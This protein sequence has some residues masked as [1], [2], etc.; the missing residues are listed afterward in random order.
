M[1]T[2]KTKIASEIVLAF[3]KNNF[4]NS[5]ESVEFIKGGEMSQ[6]FSFTAKNGNFVIRVNTS[7]RSFYKDDYAY[8]HFANPKIP[9][10]E[11][12][13]IGKLDDYYHFAIS[14]KA[15]GKHINELTNEQY[16]KTLPSLLNTL[17]A[18]HSTDTSEA[19]GYGK[20]NA[21]GKSEFPTWKDFV[22]SAKNYVEKENLLET[23]FLEKE[24]WQNIYSHIE[25]LVKF[26]PEEKFLVHGDY[27]HNNVISNQEKVT[28]VFDW[29]ESMYGDYVFDVAWMTF[30]MKQP[31]KVQATEKI[32]AGRNIPNFA[33]RLLC[34]K[35]RIGLV[36]LSF[37][38]FSQQK[39]KYDSVKQ[40]TLSLRK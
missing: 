12:I 30:W 28:G 38:A 7:P 20:W 21:E 9:I 19:I 4:D 31:E 34:Y 13:Q 18:I 32:Y 1:S 35:L 22:L 3:L 2:V 23:S 37:Y 5:V 16:V 27:S 24:V 33:E 8:K 15:E 29:A 11:I 10:P 17:D 39:E 25:K 6:A 40:I 14:T 36:S 26:C